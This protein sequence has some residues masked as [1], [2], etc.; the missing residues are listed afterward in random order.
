MIL[1]DTNIIIDFWKK[2]SNV[3]EQVFLNN[4]IYLCGVVKAELLY[5]ARDLYE[6]EK[7]KKALGDLTYI[8]TTENAWSY[9]G[10]ILFNLKKNGLTIPFQD[11]LLIS[12]SITH[13]LPIWTKDKHIKLASNI[14]T[15]LKLFKI[16]PPEP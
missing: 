11:A 7:I 12:I 6:F 10:E 9:L 3:Y 15:N 8:Q 1:I 14:I 4:E 13:N 16:T 5:G 2:P